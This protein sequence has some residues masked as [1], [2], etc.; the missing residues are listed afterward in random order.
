V[1]ELGEAL[2]TGEALLIVV[3]RDKL[4]EALRKAG[5]KAQKQL[6]RQLAVDGKELDVQLAAAEAELAR[7]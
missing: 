6:E 4:D 7:A 3:G 2:D 1:A 5:L